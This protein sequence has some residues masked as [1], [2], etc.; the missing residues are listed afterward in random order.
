MEL[1]PPNLDLM[2]LLRLCALIALPFALGFAVLAYVM[3]RERPAL[4]NWAGFDAMLFSGLA[5]ATLRGQLPDVLTYVLAD[6]AMVLAFILWRRGNRVYFGVAASDRD[7]LA[8]WALLAAGLFTGDFPRDNLMPG[9]LVVYGFLAW[10]SLQGSFELARCLGKGF[11]WLPR[12]LVVT[13]TA[14]FGAFSLLKAVLVAFMPVEE[15]L[16]SVVLLQQPQ[17]S[18][19]AYVLL[20]FFGIISVNIAFAFLL[21]IR[22]HG[23]VGRFHYLAQHDA[24]TDLANRRELNDDLEREMA[25]QQRSGEVFSLLMLDV[26]YFKRYNDDYGHLA[27]DE[28]LRWLAG[29]LSLTARREDIVAR[30]GGEEFCIVLPAAGRE[31]AMQVAERIRCAVAESR[32]PGINRRAISISIG[33]AEHGDMNETPTELIAR[34]DEALYRAK[35]GGRNRVES[36]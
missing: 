10:L 18:N 27:G 16:S 25:R 31:E 9:V 17:P 12:L 13:P 1:M 2:T 22:L 23:D 11:H 8:A 4:V 7:A 24:L 35:S 3:P 30:I 21:V 19:I 32:G 20:G 6:V 33:V 5:L 29:V 28:A 36:A 26:D 34:A 14:V 15:H